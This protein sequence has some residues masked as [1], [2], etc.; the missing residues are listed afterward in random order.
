[1]R[2]SVVRVPETQAAC[3]A[4]KGVVRS[5]KSNAEHRLPSPARRADEKKDAPARYAACLSPCQRPSSRPQCDSDAC[6]PPFADTAI[7]AVLLSVTP[8]R[9]FDEYSDYAQ[10]IPLFRAFAD[11]IFHATIG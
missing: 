3:A 6:A 4:R 10:F 9:R 1:V 7:N 11:A 5:S 8:A 2:R